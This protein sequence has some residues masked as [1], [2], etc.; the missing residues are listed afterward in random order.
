MSRLPK[1][2]LV[3]REDIQK[4]INIYLTFLSNTRNGEGIKQKCRIKNIINK[5]FFPF[6]LK[7]NKI[8]YLL[9]IVFLYI[10]LKMQKLNS[11]SKA[12]ENH[13]PQLTNIEIGKK[14]Q[15]HRLSF[16]PHKGEKQC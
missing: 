4:A 2:F 8:A 6:F 14:G 3:Y 15:K 9:E 12:R 13:F 11:L 10:I 7:K 1:G 16:P 5:D